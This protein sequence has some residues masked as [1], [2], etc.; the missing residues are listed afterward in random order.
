MIQSKPFKFKC[1]K[2]GYSIVVKPKSDAMTPKDIMNVC[3]KYNFKMDRKELNAFDNLT[4]I[5]K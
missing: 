3:P 1:L 2:C 5:F 4:N